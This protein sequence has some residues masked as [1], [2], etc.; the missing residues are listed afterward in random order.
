[1]EVSSYSDS[2]IY[3][4]IFNSAACSMWIYDLDTFNILEVNYAALDKY[5][6][7]LNEFLSLKASD[8]HKPGH[9]KKDLEIIKKDPNYNQRD[10]IWKHK[11]KNGNIFEVFVYAKNIE[12]KNHR[13]R[14]VTSFDASEQ[15][16]LLTDLWYQETFLDMLNHII[17]S[18]DSNNEINYW[19]K[20]S[21]KI[22]GWEKNE[23][24]TI[25]NVST[26][27][28]TEKKYSFEDFINK[29][30]N[31]EI[32][33][34]IEFIENKNGKVI[35]ILL[36]LTPIFHKGEYIGIVAIGSDI[37]EKLK[38]EKR[39]KESEEN[40]RTLA[41]NL[42]MIIWTANS[43]GQND[44]FSSN[45]YEYTGVNKKKSHLLSWENLIHTEDLNK[46]N[47]DWNNAVKN[48]Q[49]YESEVRIKRYD[50]VY[51][52]FK[53]TAMPLLDE[54]NNI[55]K[56]LGTCTD[57]HESKVM[58]GILEDNEAVF[59]KLTENTRDVI[60]IVDRNLNIKYI[61]PS[62][63]KILGYDPKKLIGF[64][65][66]SLIHTEDKKRLDEQIK[67][68]YETD[69]I[70]VDF[71]YELI[72]NSGE[73]RLINGV[74]MNYLNDKLINGIILNFRDFTEQAEAQMKIIENEAK[75]R[76]IIENN[77]DAIILFDGNGKIKYISPTVY[78]IS[79]YTEKELREE[80][81]L[82]I[83]YEEDKIKFS[84]IFEKHDSP[85]NFRIEIRIIH[86]NSNLIW[87][88]AT[89]KFNTIKNP[90]SYVVSFRD[91]SERK[92]YESKIEKLAYTDQLT[93]LSNRLYF[94]EQ[95]E[96]ELESDLNNNYKTAILFLD[97]NR[98]KTINDSL[99]HR[100]GDGL[101]KS[102]GQRLV[103]IL[104]KKDT[105]SRLGGDE[106]T[107]IIP[108]VKK[109]DE[110]ISVINSIIKT[111]EIPFNIENR[112]IYMTTSL[113]VSISP[114]HG[115]SA[116]KLIMNAD[117]AM[118][119]AKSVGGCS[120]I[121]YTDD[122][123]QKAVNKLKMESNLYQAIKTEKFE[124]HYQPQ[125]NLQT[126]EI[127]GSEGLIRWNY[128]NGK[129]LKSSEFI[130]L[131]EETGLI[132]KIGEIILN[133]VCKF[134]KE[135][136][137]KYN[138]F[139]PI[140]INISTKQLNQEFV[141]IV[142]KILKRTGL[143]AKYLQFEL[144]ENS[145]MKN[146]EH[147]LAIL[148]IFKNMEI[149][150]AIDDFGAGYSSLMYLNKFPIDVIKIDPLIINNIAKNSVIITAMINLAHSLNIEVIGKGAENQDQ[151][152]YLKQNNCDYVQG[153]F[154]GKPMSQKEY[155]KY[156]LDKLK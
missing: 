30:K 107:I 23:I 10:R 150:I 62:V 47:E 26:L 49:K 94:R 86:K 139:Y 142:E 73:W 129:I 120:Y 102:M 154:L 138:L 144:K 11:N 42:P 34:Q 64:N 56:W 104:D 113:G 29:V 84:E 2:D 106:F 122:M 124:V 69:D 135:I 100:A 68:I 117:S 116:E 80:Q 63:Q 60:S 140:S 130:H 54:E 82:N 70:S 19:N 148:N 145:I 45:W 77:S 76:S 7:T 127:V 149:K 24:L 44:Y 118:Y 83:I 128:S 65:C 125:F 37:S 110:V 147:S 105:I 95:L 123:N 39:I 103:D 55:K 4:Y 59:R 40:Y 108:K 79:G 72:N 52:W 78:K 153:Y 50:G 17:F 71:T 41:E 51:R 61:G 96:K 109:I 88:E 81:K 121:I 3:K 111:F 119:E 13:A 93:G 151:L 5:G 146:P 48:K 57:I 92:A 126:N 75:F 43:E 32:K 38:I 131:A 137:S 58:T 115:T 28:N 134:N 98:F 155:T 141:E 89:G 136:Q 25:H 156:L 12:Y 18:I 6:Y 114:D 143:E 53:I 33:E 14:L 27:L 85:D 91:I 22:L 1:M 46:S 31:K 35:P 101:I 132:F 9:F 21:E 20:E 99:G 97:L 36:N 66:F 8:L 133:N 152:N 112:E 67:T 15:K 16:K 90:D 74:A 87:I